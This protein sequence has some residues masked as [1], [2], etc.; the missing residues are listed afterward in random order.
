MTT[1]EYSDALA[2]FM[3]AQLGVPESE[4]FR[5]TVGL[6][7]DELNDEAEVNEAIAKVEECFAVL[8]EIL[9]GS[10]RHACEAV[11][12]GDFD[13]DFEECLAE[14]LAEDEVRP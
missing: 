8:E 11:V 1:I 13:K 5:D 2:D 12:Y 14:T 4:E 9:P 6:A 7:V 10:V 3:A